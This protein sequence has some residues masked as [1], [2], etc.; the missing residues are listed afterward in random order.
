[1]RGA[2]KTRRGTRVGTR[3]DREETWKRHGRDRRGQSGH[4]KVEKKDRD[5]RMIGYDDHMLG[6]EY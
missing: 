2:G 3:E 4:G 6:W 5:E 1:M